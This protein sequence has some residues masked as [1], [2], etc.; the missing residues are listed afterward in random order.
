MI[1]TH[2]HTHTHTH[3]YIHH[4]QFTA[5]LETINRTMSEADSGM[6]WKTAGQLFGRKKCPK[7]R[8]ER[9]WKEF[10]LERKGKVIPRWG[11]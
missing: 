11:P 7:V 4:R 3:K 1:C 2:T 6:E 10:L 5:N 8:F 9:V